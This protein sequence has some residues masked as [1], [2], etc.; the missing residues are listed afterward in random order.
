MIYKSV[1]VNI[2]SALMI[3]AAIALSPIYGLWLFSG[4][5]ADRL[6]RRR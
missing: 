1:P 3:A 2:A 6:E 4:M 5:V